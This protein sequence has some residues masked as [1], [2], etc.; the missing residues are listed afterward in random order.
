MYNHS[1]IKYGKLYRE[2]S[3]KLYGE[4]HRIT[5]RSCS[6]KIKVNNKKKHVTS[7]CD[8]FITSYLSH[9]RTSFS[10]IV[11]MSFL[12]H[13]R[14]LGYQERE[15]EMIPDLSLNRLYI[16]PAVNIVTPLSQE[17]QM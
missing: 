16:D 12:S 1:Y 2:L 17:P 3:V 5:P 11:I 10:D 7:Y 13:R 6:V 9:C 14:T 4:E 8:I 15:N